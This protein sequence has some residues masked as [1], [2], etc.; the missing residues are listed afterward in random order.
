MFGNF[1]LYFNRLNISP[2][3]ASLSLVAEL[4]NKH[5]A[6]FCFNSLSV[7]LGETISLDIN[8]IIHKI[9]VKNKGGYCFEHNKLMHDSLE[10][11]GFNVRCLLAKVLNNQEI[12]N[13]RTHRISLLE[14]EN[15]HYL[16]D[17]GFGA[18]CPRGPIK[19]EVGTE[20]VQNGLTY[21][22]ILND[23]HDYQLEMLTKDGFF[24][25]YS[26]NLNRYTDADCIMG[27]FYSSHYPHAIFMNNL[28]VSRI[29]PDVTLSLINNQYHRIQSDNTEVTHIEDH[30]HLQSIIKQDFNIELNEDDCLRIYQKTCRVI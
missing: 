4:Q 2:Q 8:D 30:L 17:A 29:Q 20:S 13:P 23:H 14:W 12:D 21:R 18:N 27:N 1:N 22:I 6:E 24:S 7:L 25:L 11:L 3:D 28:V 10:I 26:F 5:I 19:I 9:V 15:E 16:I